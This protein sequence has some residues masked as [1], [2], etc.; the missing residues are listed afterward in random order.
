MEFNNFVSQTCGVQATQG[1]G[2]Q[3]FQFFQVANEIVLSK[4]AIVQALRSLDSSQQFPNAMPQP[5][6]PQQPVQG[7][8]PMNPGASGVSPQVWEQI[9]RSLEQNFIRDFRRDSGVPMQ[10]FNDRLV[11]PLEPFLAFM[12]T[13]LRIDQAQ[14]FQIAQA[15]LITLP[16]PYGQDAFLVDIQ[17]F[18][19]RLYQG[20]QLMTPQI[21]Q[22]QQSS[23]QVIQKIY[24]QVRRY[25]MVNGGDIM[26]FFLESDL[27]HDNYVSK[28]ELQIALQKIGFTGS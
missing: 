28:Q 4:I 16:R 9:S 19:Q 25:I 12:R 26:K 6:Y 2:D 24:E 8:L 22:Q 7:L 27:D 11:A 15:F 13:L 20:S 10:M 5:G 18:E 23:Y 21:L 3:L 1:E 14:V 17:A